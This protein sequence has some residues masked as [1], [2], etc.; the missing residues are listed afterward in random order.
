MARIFTSARGATEEAR[1][2]FAPDRFHLPVMIDND[3]LCLTKLPEKEWPE[4]YK[5]QS[6][7][8]IDL[9]SICT[10]CEYTL[11]KPDYYVNEIALAVSAFN[12]YSC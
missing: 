5:T 11:H 4:Q 3:R 2:L 7:G 6:T 9:Q 8:F 12:G 1:V 10:C